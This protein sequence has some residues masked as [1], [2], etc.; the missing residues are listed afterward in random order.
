MTPFVGEIC[1]IL[2]EKSRQLA[3]KLSRHINSRA[4]IVVVG[5]IFIVAAVD[6]K[7]MPLTVSVEAAGATAVA[8]AGAVHSHSRRRASAT[9]RVHPADTAEQR[10]AA[11]RRLA[12]RAWRHR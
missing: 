11:E 12:T 6:N 1:L 9:A 4:K 10:R 3:L 5:E 8:A 2:W 7:P